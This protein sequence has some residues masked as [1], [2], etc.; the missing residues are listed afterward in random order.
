VLLIHAEDDGFPEAIRFPEKIREV[1]SNRFGSRPQCDSPI[2]IFRFVFF[3]GDLPAI[4]VEF[5][6]AWPPSC[7]VPFGHDT[8]HAVRS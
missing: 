3:I 4:A 5:A 2:K 8:M 7:G 6:F 1:A